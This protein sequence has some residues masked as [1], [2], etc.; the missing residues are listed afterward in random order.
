VAKEGQSFE[1]WLRGANVPPEKL[2]DQQRAILHGVFQFLQPSH[3][4]Y[5]SSRI[6]G[7]FLFHCGVGLGVAQ[8]ARLVGISPRS[9]FRHQKLSSTQVAQQIQHRFNGRPYG[10]LL[11]RH[12][13]SIAEFLFTHPE[14][15]R[16]ELLDFIGRTWEFRVSKVALWEFLKK[17][18]LDRASLAEA[19]QT[20]SREEEKRVT[21]AVLDAR[22]PGGLVPVVPDKFF[23]RIPSTPGLSFCGPKCSLGSPRP[24]SASPTTTVRSS[25]VF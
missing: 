21:A 19:R 13:G 8:I 6:A 14:A 3:G 2:S 10:K 23:L 9:A 22:R 17:Y 15:T 24:A 20:A 11:P 12:A 16:S 4:D 5:S 25:G 18:G 1:Q 7:H